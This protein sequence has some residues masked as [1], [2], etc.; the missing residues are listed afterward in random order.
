M[1]KKGAQFERTIR[2][3][4]EAFKDSKSTQILS[5]LQDSK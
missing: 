2:L 5:N 4:Q 1:R 3:I